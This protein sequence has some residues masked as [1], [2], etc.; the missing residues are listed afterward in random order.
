MKAWSLLLTR[1][2]VGWLL[3]LWGLDKLVNVEH[4][5]RVAETFYFGIGSGQLI[6][7]V[8]GV[9]EVLLGA[10]V[11]LGLLRRVAY[12]IAVLVLGLTAVGVWKSIV[13]PWGWFLEGPNVL[14]YPSAIVFAASLV[15]WGFVDEDRLSLDAKRS[16]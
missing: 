5:V 15:L 9:L 7:N 13:D 10:L 16:A 12:P 4:S 6:L 3:V 14:F 8:F 11:V 1:V 2:T